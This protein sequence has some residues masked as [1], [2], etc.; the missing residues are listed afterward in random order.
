MHPIYWLTIEIV[1]TWIKSLTC[2]VSVLLASERT[3]FLPEQLRWHLEFQ[4]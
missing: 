3:A 2:S 1:K 4:K